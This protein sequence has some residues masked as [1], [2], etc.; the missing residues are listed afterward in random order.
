VSCHDTLWEDISVL[1]DFEPQKNT[2]LYAVF[3]SSK[4]S[5]DSKSSALAVKKIEKGVSA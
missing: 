5:S 3:E 1:D 2:N 4:L